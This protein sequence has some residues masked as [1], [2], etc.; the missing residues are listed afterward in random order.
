MTEDVRM[1]RDTFGEIAVPNAR[2]WGAQTQRSLQNF[3]ISS[4]KQSPE[5]ITALAVIKRAAAEVNEGLGVLD[6]NKAK[7]IMQAADEI[8]DGKHPEEFP[9]AVWQTGSGTQSNMNLNE[10]IANRASELLGGERGEARKVHPNDDVNRGQS[11][12]DV[13]PTAMHVAAAYA[14]VKHLLPALKTLRETLDVKAKA[15]TDIV[16]IGR[17]HL[18][19]ATPLTLG[20]EFSGYVAQLDHGIRHVE[21]ALPHLYELAQGGTAVGTGLNAHPQ[22]ADKVA[23]AIGKLTGLPFVSAPNKFEV[24]A[25]ADALVFAHGALKTVAASL[26][27]I[28]NDIR[29]LASGP[30]CGLGELS[31]P[32]NEPGSSIMPGKVNPTQSEALTMLCAQV[33]GNDV[34]VN[35]GGA[36]GNFE[37]NVFRPMIAHNVLQ[38]VRLLA[39]G[40]HSFNDNCAVGIEPNRERIDTLLNESLMLVTAL[41]PHIGYDKAAQIAKKAHKE[42][43]T[44]KASALALGYVTE[45]QFDEWVRPK[46]MVGHSAG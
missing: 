28:A 8:I 39:D 38:S 16:K 13:F 31:I 7:A 37:L 33:F 44:L 35:I 20:Q 46:D 18:Q 25:G 17:T 42:G 32:E 24:M 3:R 34:A 21:S 45:Q 40:A 29:W 19:D 11:S 6:G 15:F 5:L 4:E 30:R 2:L 1:E 14:I 27:K 41:N 9:L 36:S 10:V 26:N 22:F 43:T 23:A 12:N